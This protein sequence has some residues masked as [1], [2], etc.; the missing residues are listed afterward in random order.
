VRFHILRS[1]QIHREILKS[2]RI[3][4][5]LRRIDPP[6]RFTPFVEDCVKVLEE[7][8][9]HPN[10]KSAVALVRLQGILERV[11]VAPYFLTEGNRRDDVLRLLFSGTPNFMAE[12]TRPL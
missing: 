9:G 12:E 3:S 1:F 4:L 6:Q 11:C 7:L 5:Y 10:D 2:S 8:G